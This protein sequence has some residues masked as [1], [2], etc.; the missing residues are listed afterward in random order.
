MSPAPTTPILP[1]PVRAA[2][3]RSLDGELVLPLLPDTAARVMALCND[4]MCDANRLAELIHRD[5]AM[6]GHVLH[7]S[8]SAAYAPK[9]PIVSL[10]QAVSRLGIG[11]IC[12]IALAVALKGKVFQVPGFQ[13]RVREM[14]IHACAT[15][16]YAKEIARHLRRN[17]E[18]A[19][20]CGLLHD[21]GMP[22]VMQMLCDLAKQHGAKTIPAA[23]MESAM[24]EFHAEVGS[25]IAEHWQLATWI[26]DATLF[27]HDYT[28]A[29]DHREEV[30]ITCL[31]D[32]LAHWALDPSTVEADFP[33]EHAV[34]QDLNIYADDLMGLLAKRARTL[35]VAESLT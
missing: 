27:H 16:M 6:A 13:S 3:R 12:E 18:S 11:T 34:I 15:G 24:A 29:G 4:E 2:L 31:A 33:A 30:M 23:V 14:W 28:K 20:M 7:V 32:L 10:Q 19:F 22:L 1:G 26:R 21:V 9:E 25:K 17:V 8:N 5:P 35:E